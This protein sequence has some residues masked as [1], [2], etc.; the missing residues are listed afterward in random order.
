M[1]KALIRNAISESF[2]KL[3]EHTNFKAIKEVFEIEYVT[4]KW[5]KQAE[6]I[7][8]A[9][10]TVGLDTSNKSIIAA[11]TYNLEKKKKYK[12][13]IPYNDAS[14][15]NEEEYNKLYGKYYDQ[16]EMIY[17]PEESINLF[18][19]IVIYDPLKETRIGF[20][21]VTTD[22]GNLYIKLNDKILQRY[23][24]TL[25]SFFEYKDAILETCLGFLNTPEINKN[26]N[27]NSILKRL[28]ANPFVSEKKLSELIEQLK[29]ARVSVETINRFK[30]DIA[31]YMQK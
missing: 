13:F 26:T 20:T 25:R 14:K 28:I 23:I 12:Y 3:F 6:E 30:R 11:V 17:I 21:L 8:I 9:S 16:Y 1:E 31:K 7:W 29:T 24:K 10:M 22:S 5:E 15:I 2:E 4:E 18:E 19:E 27:A